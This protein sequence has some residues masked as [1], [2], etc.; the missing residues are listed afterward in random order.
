MNQTTSEYAIENTLAS[1]W[2]MLKSQFPTLRIRDAA[3]KL[4]V[5]EAELLTTTI[6]NTATRLEGDWTEL[7]KRLP[8]LGRVMSLTRNNSCIL[9]HKGSFQK[10]EILGTSPKTM[11][12]VIGPIETRIFFHDWKHGFAVKQVTPHGLQQS[13]QFFNASGIAITKIFLQNPNGNWPGSNQ[14]AYDEL[15]TDFTS[16]DQSPVI[17]IEAPIVPEKR[18]GT[19]TDKDALLADWALLTDTHQ[20]YGLLQKYKVHRLEAIQMAENRF[21]FP[22]LKSA[23]RSLLEIAA[24]EELPIMIFAGNKGNLQIHQGKIQTIR[25]IDQWINILD[26][27]FNMHLREDH[28]DSVWIVKKPSDDGVITSIEIFD[29]EGNLIVQFFGLRKPGKPELEGWRKLIEL[30]PVQE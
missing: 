10:V 23:I 27:E 14:Q 22:L 2:T 17:S 1:A 7:V 29:S 26:P 9:E 3:E 21:T 20:F 24:S 15:V 16:P 19:I 4:G 11:A 12:T 13:L 25:V 30:L 8:S 18:S 6:G 28:I 5:S